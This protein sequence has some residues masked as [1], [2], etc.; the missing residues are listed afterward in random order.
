MPF[1]V[2]P[3]GRGKEPLGGAVP[4]IIVPDGN[5]APVP[6]G[7]PVPP[8]TTGPEPVGKGTTPDVEV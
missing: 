7:L 5:G 3:V 8:G 1:P 4:E 6:E 2:R